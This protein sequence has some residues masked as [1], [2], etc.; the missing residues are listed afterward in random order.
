MLST[1][2]PPH[3][4]CKRNLN[5]SSTLD[6]ILIRD[7]YTF[8][9]SVHCLWGVVWG[10]G[11]EKG[12][13]WINSLLTLTKYQLLLPLPYLIHHHLQHSDSYTATHILNN[14]AIFPSLPTLLSSFSHSLYSCSNFAY[15]SH[16]IMPSSNQLL[17]NKEEVTHIFQFSTITNDRYTNIL[18]IQISSYPAVEL[19]TLTSPS[20][21][22]L[23]RY[24]PKPSCTKVP[25]LR[26]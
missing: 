25:S 4:R 19:L 13:P 8:V 10:G 14:Y 23:L 2:R 7:N 21:T 5:T 9:D 6:S 1:S 17:T 12:G 3:S 15:F 20:Y 22:S 26:V 18:K 16:Q 24:H 11:G